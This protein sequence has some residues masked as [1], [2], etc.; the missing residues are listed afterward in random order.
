MYIGPVTAS[1]CLAS[2]QCG[3]HVPGVTPLDGGGDDK[4]PSRWQGTIKVVAVAG[5][6]IAIHSVT[7]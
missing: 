1:V 5:A 7:E 6:V 3:Q 2:L 4:S